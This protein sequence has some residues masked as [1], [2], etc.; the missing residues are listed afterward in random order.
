MPTSNNP[1][2]KNLDGIRTE[3]VGTIDT[4]AT[5]QI[6]KEIL[7]SSSPFT[8]ILRTPSPISLQMVEEQPDPTKFK[9][10]PAPVAVL[11]SGHF[12]YLFNNRPLPVGIVELKDLTTI[13]KSAKMLVVADG[14]WLINQI[15]PK[16]QSPYP[17]GWDR[18]AEQQY[19]NKAFLENMVDFLQNDASLVTLRNREVKLRLLDQAKLKDE[20][21]VWQVINVMAP[22]IILLCIGLIQ[23]YIR[24]RKYT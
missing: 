6:K 10:K 22:L 18:Y 8:R 20:K 7:L 23:Q 11:L 21:L 14:D 13:S 17:L 16:D 5:P 19:A 2:I 1:I 3:F 4:I 12:P 15:N 9:T 24:R